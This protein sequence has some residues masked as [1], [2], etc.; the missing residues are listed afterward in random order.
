MDPEVSKFDLKCDPGASNLTSSGGSFLLA[1][2]MHVCMYVRACMYVMYVCMHVC[3]P[4][5]GAFPESH[6]SN[7]LQTL[8]ER[9]TTH[10]K[11]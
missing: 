1:T 9:I 3:I 11:Y 4:I 10:T 2:R 8:L 7:M 5:L 6:G